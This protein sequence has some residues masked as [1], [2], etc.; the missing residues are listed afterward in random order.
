VAKPDL[1]A[2][3][4]RISDGESIDWEAVLRD[5]PDDAGR[6]VVR[7]LR[8]LESLSSFHRTGTGDEEPVHD[9]TRTVVSG[10]SPAAALS[11][12]RTIPIEPF[13][14]GALEVREPLGEGGFGEVY[15]AWDTTLQREVA[16]KL[17]KREH[18]GGAGFAASVLHEARLLARVRHPHVVTVYG[19]DT[20]DGRVGLWMELVRGRSLAQWVES[21]GR[22]GA[23]EAAVLGLDLCRALAAVHGAGLVHRDVKAGNVMREEGGRILLMDFGAVSDTASSDEGSVSGTPRYIA[24]EIYTGEKATP[25]SDLFSLGVL[26]YHLVTGRYPVD[27]HTVGELREKI[28]RREA[29]LL[30]DERPDLPEAFVQVVE[31]ALAWRPE[32]RYPSA[33]AMEQALSAFLGAEGGAGR[34]ESRAL[35]AADG[36]AWATA[37]Q[38]PHEPGRHKAIGIAIGLVVAIAALAVLVVPSQFNR[39]SAPPNGTSRP[40]PAAPAE[41]KGASA[42][43]V[44]APYTVEASLQRIRKDGSRDRLDSGSRLALRDQLALEVRGSVP[45]YVYVID[46]D[47][48]GNAYALFPLPDLTPKNPLPAETAVLLPGVDAERRQSYWSVTTAGGREH[49]MVLAS[50][51]RIVEFEAEM[52]NLRRPEPGVN[53]APIPD[54]AMGRLRGLRGLGG[55]VRATHP[56]AAPAPEKATHLFEM[57]EK[58]AGKKEQVT[59]PWLRRIDLENPAP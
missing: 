58:L 59:G 26:L 34:P 20:H 19:A 52:A 16:L 24:P 5:T 15:R 43:P 17:L 3:A 28:A 54:E 50:P 27:A 32:D 6:K 8:L 31:R 48:K 33:G 39:F 45:L 14:W 29:R 40:A 51:E 44:P 2:L 11:A 1:I 36:A 49:I 38:R 10:E 55:L 56:A 12:V 41:G 46:E 18:R 57:A 23:R 47:E 25:R 35:E 22:L 13:T 21:Q 9:A 30:R 37:V 42:T 53:A 7:N 4:Q